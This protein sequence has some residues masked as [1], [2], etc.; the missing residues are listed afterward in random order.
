MC[1]YFVGALVVA[2]LLSQPGY[3]RAQVTESFHCELTRPNGRYLPNSPIPG[4]A[5]SF[6]GNDTIA[7]VLGPEGSTIVFEPGGAG[8]VLP[9]GAL[10]TKFLWAKIPLPMR[11]EGRRLDAQAPPLRYR[12]SGDH[13]DDNFQPSSL[14]F[15]TPGCWEITSRVGKSALTFVVQVVKIGD[16]PSMDSEVRRRQAMERVAAMRRAT[17]TDLGLPSVP[18]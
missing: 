12:L 6:Y 3:A 18:W 10:Q 14:I 9:D 7:V 11:I 16:G 15:A 4:R 5:S 17:F 8:F 1:R 13:A 2:L